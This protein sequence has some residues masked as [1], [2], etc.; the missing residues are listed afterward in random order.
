[1]ATHPV[2]APAD[3]TLAARKNGLKAI[4]QM[5]NGSLLVP[6]TT[7][8]AMLHLPLMSTEMGSLSRR[9]RLWPPTVCCCN[10]IITAGTITCRHNG[11]CMIKMGAQNPR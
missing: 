2:S 9:R 6:C 4:V 5:A 11:L 3:Q 7:G 1:M 8:I 10:D